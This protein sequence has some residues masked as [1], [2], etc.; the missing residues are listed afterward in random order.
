MTA[1]SVI[2]RIPSLVCHVN[3]WSVSGN[4]SHGTGSFG[5]LWYAHIIPWQLYRIHTNS[6]K[7]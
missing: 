3:F 6:V 7:R 4:N 5:K 2:L 1:Y